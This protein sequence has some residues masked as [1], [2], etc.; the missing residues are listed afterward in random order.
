L[1][2]LDPFAPVRREALAGCLA[3]FPTS[4][5]SR[6]KEALLDPSAA[7]RDFARFYLRERGWRDF[8]SHYRESLEKN[9]PSATAVAGLGETGSI[10]DLPI[11]FQLT[12]A[13]SAR[14]R[15]LA[16][17]GI[18]R[19]SGLEGT[20]PLLAALQDES[21]RVSREAKKSLLDNPRQL[22]LID[23][24]RI[25]Q[26]KQPKHVRRAGAELLDRLL[27]WSAVPLLL[28][29]G[30]DPDHDL[31]EMARRFLLRRINRVFTKPSTSEQ[32]AILEALQRTEAA[33]AGAFAR[34]YSD[35]F[36]ARMT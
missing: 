22:T 32:A 31:A 10:N 36:R 33:G 17:R 1:A 25:V 20:K 19:I 11:L 21:I 4:A 26:A 13:R 23:L 7:V 35:W 24:E 3:R 18:A 15:Q 5:E 8:A 14:L 30:T 9:G 6:L 2:R 12:F 27:S 16:V 29:L 34:E 28:D